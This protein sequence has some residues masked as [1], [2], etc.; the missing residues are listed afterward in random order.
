MGF[1]IVL[2]F[3]TASKFSIDLGRCHRGVS[4]ELAYISNTRIVTNQEKTFEFMLNAL[5]LTGGFELSLFET[6]TGLSRDLIMPQVSE[7]SELGLLSVDGHRLVSSTQGLRFLNE[8][9]ERF[10]PEDD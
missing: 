9:T 10:L 2:H 4:Q 6:R 1:E 5:R 8:M 7:L 3:Q